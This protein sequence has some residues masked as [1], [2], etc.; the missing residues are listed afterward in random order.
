MNPK[1]LKEQIEMLGLQAE[2]VVQMCYEVGTQLDGVVVN[3]NG[4]AKKK[5]LLSSEERLRLRNMV[6]SKMLKKPKSEF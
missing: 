6:Q 2:A 3:P 1:S 4:I 5:Q